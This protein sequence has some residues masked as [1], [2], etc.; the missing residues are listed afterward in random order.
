MKSSGE[1]DRDIEELVREKEKKMG[2]EK[3]KR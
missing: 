3:G 1:K 2:Q